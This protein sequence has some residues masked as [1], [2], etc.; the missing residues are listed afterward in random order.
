MDGAVRSSSR[1]RVVECE[2]L[3]ATGDGNTGGGAVQ[4]AGVRWGDEA[5]AASRLSRRD[6]GSEVL[7]QCRG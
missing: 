6:S 4:D 1:G 3:A 5:P 7:D 2:A